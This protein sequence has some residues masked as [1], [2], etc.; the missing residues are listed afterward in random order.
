MAK[1][2]F[3]ARQ[4]PTGIPGNLMLEIVDGTDAVA[5]FLKQL[6]QKQRLEADKAVEESRDPR[7]YLIETDL[8]VHYMRRTLKQNRLQWEL[9]RR[10]GA[11]DHVDP[12]TVHQAV[13][14]IVYPREEAYGT[15]VPKDGAELS[16]IEY[17]QVIEWLIRECVD[18]ADPVDIQDIWILFTE[19]RYAQA[20][21]PLEGSYADLEDYKEKH[22]CCEVC[23]TFLL[24]RD[25]DGVYRHV[26]HLSHIIS[27][28]AG[29]PDAPWNT[30]VLCA[31]HHVSGESAMHQTGW[32]QTLEIA[33]WLRPKYDRAQI[34]FAQ[35]TP[36][37]DDSIEG[38][39]KTAENEQGGHLDRGESVRPDHEP[40]AGRDAQDPQPTPEK[41]VSADE[42]HPAEIVRDI[43]EG[44]IVEGSIP[45]RISEDPEEPER[46]LT[47]DEEDG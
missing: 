22:P 33:P 38:S 8:Q 30:F 34:L 13:K 31:G 44:E 37:E 47:F 2:R 14:E 5:H 4:V 25:S 35:T 10:I 9:C 11:A 17:A 26:G 42:R 20:H 7:E 27:R 12:D 19:W 6:H 43:F 45:E 46:Q 40:P 39:A 29:G 23:G 36:I 3:T 15:S 16:T 28:G 1:V 32:S 21:D 18:R 41:V 24:Q